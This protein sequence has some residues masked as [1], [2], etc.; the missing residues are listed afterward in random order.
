MLNGKMYYVFFKLMVQPTPMAAPQNVA[1]FARQ[2]PQLTGPVYFDISGI[3][4]S[5]VKMM[6]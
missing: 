4:S 1:A 3:I 2:A 6:V 5:K